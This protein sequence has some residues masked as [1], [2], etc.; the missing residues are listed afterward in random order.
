M[1]EKIVAKRSYARKEKHEF[2]RVVNITT[3]DLAN[4][5]GFSRQYVTRAIDKITSDKKM[6]LS[7][8]E[9][10]TR[11]NTTKTNRILTELTD[12]CDKKAIDISDKDISPIQKVKNFIDGEIVV[13]AMKCDHAQIKEYIKI[14]DYLNKYQ[15]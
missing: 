13:K 10:L 4:Y 7:L 3:A 1:E 5:L 14:L 8:K 11:I 15:M 9:A 12:Y 2:Y 6:L